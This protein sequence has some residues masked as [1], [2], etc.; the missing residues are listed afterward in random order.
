MRSLKECGEA[1]AKAASASGKPSGGMT[2]SSGR[3]GVD[4]VSVEGF[5]GWSDMLGPFI[6]LLIHSVQVG[7]DDVSD[8]VAPRQP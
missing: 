2:S 8:Q 1:S 5:L 6:G 4:E 7:V 3:V